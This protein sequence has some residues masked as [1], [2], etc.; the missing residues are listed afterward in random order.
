M[1]FASKTDVLCDCGTMESAARNPDLPIGFNSSLNEFNFV[2]GAG[3]MRIYH[4][5]FCGGKAPESLRGALFAQIPR[6]E[7]QRLFALTEK[8]KTVADVVGS[9][10]QPDRDS[11]RGIVVGAPE[12]DGQAPKLTAHRVLVYSKLSEVADVHAEVYPEDRVAISLHGKHIG[13]PD[14]AA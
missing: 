13:P 14:G 4:C 1:T 11:A 10:G 5:P 2:Y 7:Q 6:Q 9:L 3:K 8:F 12:R